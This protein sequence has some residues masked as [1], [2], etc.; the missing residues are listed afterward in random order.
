LNIIFKYFNSLKN[1][2]NISPIDTGGMLRLSLY[3]V[4]GFNVLIFLSHDFSDYSEKT[5]SGKP[6]HSAYCTVLKK[7]K[8]VD[9]HIVNLK[10]VGT[11]P[12]FIVVFP[13][14]Y[15]LPHN[16]V[17]SSPNQRAPPL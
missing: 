9:L 14:N 17:V 12:R 8:N 7:I 11:T 4:W 10:F 15:E 13:Q 5:D 16:E 6:N 3:I 1:G 2:F